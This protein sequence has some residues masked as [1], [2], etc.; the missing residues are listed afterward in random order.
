MA[1]KTE[2]AELQRK[3]R[4]DALKILRESEG[5]P[6]SPRKAMARAR[7]ASKQLGYP[8]K[9]YSDANL[10]QLFKWARIEWD[11]LGKWKS[12]AAPVA[13]I[14]ALLTWEKERALQV[15]YR[16]RYEKAA[17]RRLATRAIFGTG[18]PKRKRRLLGFIPLPG[19]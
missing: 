17:A 1:K 15:E 2:V 7:K 6:I 5:V 18:T 13:I 19:R 9:P 10:F 8:V 11:K 16:A 3:S 4:F 14:S 12:L